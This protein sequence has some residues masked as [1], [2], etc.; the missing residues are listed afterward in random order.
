MLQCYNRGCGLKFDPDNN[1]DESCR[2]HPGQPFF[3]DAY[4]GWSCCNRKSVDFTEFLNMKGCTVSKHSDVKPP[5][6][7]KPPQK[8][9][10]NVEEVKEIRKPIQAAIKRPSF[11]SPLIQI[12]PTVL[13]ALKD[14]IDTLVPKTATKT[15]NNSCEIP[16]G[17]TCRNGGCNCTYTSPE[18]DET[19][20][21]HHPGVPIFH[22]GLKFWSCCTK[23]TSDFTAFMN[24]PG[25]SVGNHK[26]IEDES[27]KKTVACRYDW[28]QTSSNVIVA[29]YAK[30]YHYNKST[31]KVNPIRLN[32]H[33]VFPDQNDSE[34]NLDLELRGIINVE[35]TNVKMYGTKV[36]ITMPKIE[37]GSW[38]KLDYPR[39]VVEQ[40]TTPKK[41]IK[42]QDSESDVDLDD[43]EPVKGVTITNLD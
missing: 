18:A 32:V 17:T 21:R 2:H 42:K 34:F 25:C 35:K 11:D 30:L 41:D 40:K 36:E 16:I 10:E 27:D 26:W 37:A 22:E 14:A 28:H 23:R 5:E 20:C 6:P 24:Q 33:L 43:I 19:E 31:V 13:P 12:T 39:P 29:V 3:H 1:N 38:A 9:E 7:E 4:K 8:I 15:E